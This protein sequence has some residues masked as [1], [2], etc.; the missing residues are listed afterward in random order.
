MSVKEFLYLFYKK[1]YKRLFSQP[2]FSIMKRILIATLFGLVFGLVCFF[3]ATMNGKMPWP[4]TVQILLSRTLI[5]FAIGISC[6]NVKH[7]SLHGIVMGLIFSLPL[8]FSTLMASKTPEFCPTYIFVAT[9]IMGIVYGFL[10]E[11][12][13]TVVFKAKQK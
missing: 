10:I 8:A 5:G 11:L 7:W 4:V 12:L 1:F 6:L 2:K 13:T 9:M 3:M